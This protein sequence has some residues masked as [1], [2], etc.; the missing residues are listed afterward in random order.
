MSKLKETLEKLVKGL[1]AG[2]AGCYDEEIET[3]L[4]H[5]T[6]E[7]TGNKKCLIG[8]L[9]DDDFHALIDKKPFL[10][11]N[12]KSFED[13]YEGKFGGLVAVDQQFKEEVINRSRAL[14][15]DT[16]LSRTQ[17]MALQN[18]HDTAFM[19]RS[20]EDATEEVLDT[21]RN[22]IAGDTKHISLALFDIN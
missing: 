3:C 1:E 4:Y 15:I 17:A 11:L 8:Y 14:L 16:G 19:K 10:Y 9:M 7:N 12:T 2:E 5:E 21:L 6:G 22:V 20:T 18:L 13:F